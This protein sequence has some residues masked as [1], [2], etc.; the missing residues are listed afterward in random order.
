MATGDKWKDACSI[1]DFVAEDIRG[2]EVPLSKYAGHVVLIV[3]VAS[4]CGFTDSNYKQLQELH[5]KYASHNPPLSILGFPCNQFGSQEPG[6][7]EEVAKFCSAKYNVKFD[8][9]G[10]VDVNGDDAHP[11]WKYLKHK[12]GGTFGDRIKAP[13]P[14]LG[15]FDLGSDGCVPD[16]AELNTPELSFDLQGFIA[17]SSSSAHSSS[18][19]EETLFTDL[20]TEQQKRYGGHPFPMPHQG[21]PLNHAEHRYGSEAGLGIKQEP[22]DQA[23]YSSCREQQSPYARGLLAF[24]GLHGAPQGPQATATLRPVPV[25]SAGQPHGLA[26]QG[27]LSLAALP[28]PHANGGGPLGHH[29]GLR[30]LGGQGPAAPQGP[31]PPHG[32]HKA[33]GKKLLDK[34]SDEYRRRRERNNI[35]VRKSREKA[36]QRSRD[37]ER[38][39]SEL[40]RENDSLRKKVELLTKELAV[41]K[42]LLTNVGVPPENVDNEVARSLQGY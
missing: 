12:Q 25:F 13:A 11:L 3:N 22:L 23:E 19:L 14:P 37:T 31:K 1:H 2:Q 7:N 29:N 4:Q 20:L 35:A 42:S 24:P 8:L 21:G 6:S 38:K 30:P 26:P 17:D 39:V 33:S 28:P 27:P 9:F 10:K 15:A 40:N 32:Q 41:L 36:K 18:S 5:D 34:G 16:L